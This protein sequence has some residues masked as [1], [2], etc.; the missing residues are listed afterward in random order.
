[1]NL[2][3]VVDIAERVQSSYLFALTGKRTPPEMLA[4]AQKETLT[5]TAQFIID[6]PNTTV[7]EL[8][9]R[10]VCALGAR[11]YVLG[12]VIDD[13]TKQHPGMLP[14]SHLAKDARVATVL[15]LDT[16][17]ALAPFC[18]E[19]QQADDTDTDDDNDDKGDDATKK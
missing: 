11:G 17:R 3:N 14:F 18:A 16:V 1:M 9:E 7:E 6:N 2:E 10:W 8:H 12:P 4:I 13:D 5:E 19:E 15:F